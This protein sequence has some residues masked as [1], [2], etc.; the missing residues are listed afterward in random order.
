MLFSFTDFF[1]TVVEQTYY[2]SIRVINKVDKPVLFLFAGNEKIGEREIP[3]NSIQTADFISSATSEP[4][5]ITFTAFLMDGKHQLLLNNKLKLSLIPDVTKNV[6]Q[7]VITDPKGKVFYVNL[8][9][10][11]EAGK[12]VTLVWSEDDSPQTRDIDNLG[13]ANLTKKIIMSDDLLPLYEFQVH[14]FGTNRNLLINRQQIFT[15]TPSDDPESMT[16][17]DITQSGKLKLPF[18][19]VKALSAIIFGGKNFRRYIYIYIK[20]NKN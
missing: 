9:V 7:V 4:N 6:S 13:A 20:T 16:Y 14:E 3:A 19:S 8:Q 12:K 10:T 18:L 1:A 17:I 2:T 11:N 15:V 5:K